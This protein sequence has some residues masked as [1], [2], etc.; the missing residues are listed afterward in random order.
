M[1]LLSKIFDFIKSLVTRPGVHTFL[2]KYQQKAIEV[3]E[4]LSE[5]NNGAPLDKWWDSAFSE[6][7]AMVQAD[8]HELHDNW[9]AIALNL[10]Y[11]VFLGHKQS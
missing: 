9:I 2:Q 4:R 10:G 7:K 1:S 3:I 11:E 8:G 5:V 6:F